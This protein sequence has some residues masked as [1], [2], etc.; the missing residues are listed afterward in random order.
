MNAPPPQ[1]IFI[2]YAHGDAASGRLRT[3]LAEELAKSGHHVFTD[4]NIEGSQE[5]VDEITEHAAACD[6]FV[7]LIS[8]A[9]LSSGWVRAEVKQAHDRF[10]AEKRPRIFV[11]RLTGKKFNDVRWSKYLDDYQ[12]LPCTTRAD[13]AIVRDAILGRMTF[14]AADAKVRDAAVARRR[15]ILIVFAL[16]VAL[17]LAALL[18]YLLVLVPLDNIQKLRSA[19]P[20]IGL[21]GTQVISLS[22]A[23]NDRDAAVRVCRFCWS[24][25]ADAAYAQF[26]RLWS[27]AHLANARKWMNQGEVSK[28]FVLAAW[29]AQENGGKLD[30]GFRGV[31]DEGNYASLK[32]T[33]RTASTLGAGLAVSSDGTQIAA[34]NTLWNL[35]ANTRC[36]LAA[37]AINVVAFGPLG[38]YT[39]GNEEVTQ[40]TNCRPGAQIPVSDERVQDLAVAQD[41][42]VAVVVRKGSDVLLHKGVTELTLPHAQPVRSVAF[43]DDGSFLVTTSGK[44]L[45]VWNLTVRNHPPHPNK[46]DT[47]LSLRGAALNGDY[48]A[49]NGAQKVKIWRLR[50]GVQFL[51]EFAPPTPVRSIAL[52]EDAVL[53][54]MVSEEGVFS[55][56]V[57]R[58]ALRRI[59]A[60]QSV[61]S[62]VVFSDVLRRLIVKRA[63]AVELWDLEPSSSDADDPEHRLARWMVKFALI[64]DENGRITPHDWSENR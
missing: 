3:Y 26:L 44:L 61:T 1:K 18:A 63:D 57:A 41:G 2:S 37:G 22:E 46:I 58:M 23:K 32:K 8:E 12:H 36:T 60:R 45:S 50:P 30:D 59:G 54:A 52:S 11:V 40:W 24:S 35:A 4:Q 10:E 14:V 25:R 42:T 47:G 13:F 19:S 29:V 20:V 15:R 27:D 6:C 49:V 7:V 43:A 39:G 16:A 5:W 21:P 33:L 28:G 56:Q 53:L 17:P 48:V 34:G 55:G 31:Y 64:V 9:A 62:D 51:R 38:L